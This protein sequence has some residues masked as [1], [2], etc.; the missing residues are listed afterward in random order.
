MNTMY[1][2]TKYNILYYNNLIK[3]ENIIINI[4]NL[5]YV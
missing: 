1:K 2:K 3:I 5:K 4:N